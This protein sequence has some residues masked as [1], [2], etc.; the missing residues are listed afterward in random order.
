MQKKVF[1]QRNLRKG[2][3]GGSPYL[4]YL[5]IAA[6]CLVFLV[7]IVPYL[8]K[9]KN[10]DVTK[11]PMPDRGSITKE[12][13]KPM[14]PTVPENIAEQVKPAET[15]LDLLRPEHLNL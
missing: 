11:R 3:G 9:G 15:P 14:E 2:G 12:V 8:F 7:L 1:L 6:V 5:V 10:K 13:P 4:K